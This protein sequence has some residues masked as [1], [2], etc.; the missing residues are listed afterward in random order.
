MGLL[1]EM[2]KR[3]IETHL[4][5]KMKQFTDHSVI[6]ESGEF[7]ADLIIF[8]PGMTGNSWFNNTQLPRSEGGN[9]QGQQ[10]LPG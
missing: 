2:K 10:P 8:M 7:D 6:T 5:H 1:K 3:D 9:A 4:G